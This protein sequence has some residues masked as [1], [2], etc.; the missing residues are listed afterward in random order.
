[1]ILGHEECVAVEEHEF[2]CRP[3]HFLESQVNE[4]LF[5]IVKE[6]TVWLFLSRPRR[7]DW[8]GNVVLSERDLLPSL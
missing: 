3:K 8:S 6:Q 5:Q 7:G 2:N 4:F 1:M